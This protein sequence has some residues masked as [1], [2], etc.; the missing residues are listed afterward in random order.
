MASLP[1]SIRSRRPQQTSCMSS[2]RNPRISV[3]SSS[4]PLMTSDISSAEKA[5]PARRSACFS[6]IIGKSCTSDSMYFL[7]TSQRSTFWRALT[8]LNPPL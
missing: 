8:V 3:P 1:L 5:D 2:T 6:V 7:L 4:S